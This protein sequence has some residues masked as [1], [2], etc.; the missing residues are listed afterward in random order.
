LL[1]D[2]N[3]QL[4]GWRNIKEDNVV[5]KIVKP[6]DTLIQK[7]YSG[8][9]VFQSAVL[10]LIPF[11]GKFSLI[12]VYLHLTGTHKIVGYNHTGDKWIDVGRPESVPIAE[13]MF[14]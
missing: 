12:D 11:S 14:V 5:E 10:D 6:A 8:I 2:E 9:A 3:N 4:C 13:N 1:F 7:A